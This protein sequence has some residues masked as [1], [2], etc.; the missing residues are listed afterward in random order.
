MV[1]RGNPPFGPAANFFQKT[2]DNLLKACYNTDTKAKEIK[3]E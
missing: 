3:N 1:K 2:L